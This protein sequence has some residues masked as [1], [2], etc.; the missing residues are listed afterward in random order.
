MTSSGTAQRGNLKSKKQDLVRHEIWSAA[1]ELF[2]LE[3]FDDVTID[4]IA[5]QAGV[6][7]RTFFRYFASKDDVMG[8]TM[9]SFGE[10]LEQAIC[11]ETASLTAFEAAKRS[12]AQVLMRQPSSTITNR[13]VQIS[14]R[15]S[16]ALSAQFL[17]LP[18]VEE[19]L[20][21]A[22]AGRA[23]R[24]REPSVDDRII[25]SVAFAATKLCVDLWV[26]RPKRPVE[27]IVEDVFAR[28][29][30]ICQPTQPAANTTDRPRSRPR[31]T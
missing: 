7:R 14:K 1:I 29:S 11:Q 16:A 8:S 28:L 26:G 13:V 30:A 31:S 20:A 25:A 17:Q 5:D 24:T 12:V 22:F 4:Q 15:S 10:A 2:Y 19:K 18:A 3:G 27:V 6:S 9:K 23:G 21:R